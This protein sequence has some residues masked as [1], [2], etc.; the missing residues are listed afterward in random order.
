MEDPILRRRDRVPTITVR[1]DI[2]DSLQPPDVSHGG[3]VREAPAA[4]RYPAAGYNIDMAGSI[5][6]AAKANA[7]L[8]PIF[9]IM[10]LLMMVVIILQVRSIL[11]DG[12]GAADRAAGA[13]RASCRRCWSPASPSGSTP[14]SG[15]IALGRHPD[16]QHADPDRT[17]S[18]II[19]QDGPD[20][21]STRWSR[22][23]SSGRAQ[24]ILT[25]LA[26]VLAFVP[27]TTSVFWGSMAFTLIGGTLRRHDPDA[28]VPAG[29]LH[30]LVRDRFGRTC[31][32][33][34]QCVPA[35]ASPCWRVSARCAGSFRG[36]SRDECIR[37]RLGAAWRRFAAV[38]HAMD[39]DG[40]AETA[41]LVTGLD[42]RVRQQAAD[43][44]AISA[45]MDALAAQIA[46]SSQRIRRCRATEGGDRRL[47]A[48][49]KRMRGSEGASDAPPI[50]ER[51]TR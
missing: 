20:R 37:K 42:A 51:M 26:A 40:P 35:P 3:D 44:A 48:K 24:S 15:L 46:Q 39:Y 16:A 8:A 5:E 29:A 11:G 38:A 33:S 23:R 6:E 45:R 30:A 9:P 4:D 47:V 50:D 2:A 49:K 43:L 14:S 36:G 13:G 22:P 25:A 19:E 7:A 12:D 31:P 41:S 18:R 21:P 28:G 27:L 34:R 32:A 17:D 1:G 10:I